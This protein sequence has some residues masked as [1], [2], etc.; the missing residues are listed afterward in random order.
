ML[1]ARYQLTPEN[2]GSIACTPN[3]SLR[4]LYPQTDLECKFS[5]A[6][7]LVATL[8][9]GEVNLN[10]CTE[11]FLRRQDVQ[12][13]L[14]K[15]TYIEKVPGSEGFIRV[16]AV[17]GQ[18][19]EQPLVR[20]TDLKVHDEIQQKFHLCAIPVAGETKAKEIESLVFGIEELGSITTLTRLLG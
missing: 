8:M 18:V 2:V 20:P 11:S 4:C 17:T 5:A 7:S 13:L 1:K 19:Y 6:F 16:K 3:R 12:A 9:D 10:N 14:A 15:T